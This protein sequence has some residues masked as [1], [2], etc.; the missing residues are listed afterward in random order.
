MIKLSNL[1][2]NVENKENV[3][4][5]LQIEEALPQNPPQEPHTMTENPLHINMESVNGKI[6]ESVAMETP[7]STPIQP[8]PA[9]LI[10]NLEHV[11][12]LAVVNPATLTAPA[13]AGK[14]MDHVKEGISVDTDTQSA[15]PPAEA[16][17]RVSPIF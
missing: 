7:A 13:I 16:K 2:Q 11:M 12:P 8:Q 4:L 5:H 10:A 6:K 17:K 9:P 15:D 14:E 3:D 1:N